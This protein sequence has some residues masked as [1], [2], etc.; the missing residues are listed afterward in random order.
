MQDQN[1]ES[2]DSAATC[3]TA[4][5]P[6]RL[7]RGLV[8]VGLALALLSVVALNVNLAVSN[9]IVTRA[10]GVSGGVCWIAWRDGTDPLAETVAWGQGLCVSSASDH[11]SLGFGSWHWLRFP[12]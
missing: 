8:A 7:E 11:F 12:G 2:P 5:G 9:A 6:A 4:D 1:T 3:G 10:A